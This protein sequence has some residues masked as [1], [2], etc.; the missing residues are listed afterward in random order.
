VVDG[1]FAARLDLRLP[2]SLRERL[3]AA[4]R[5]DRRPVTALARLLLEEALDA[6]EQPAPPVGTRT[7]QLIDAG[8]A[9]MP[10]R[11]RA[12]YEA[13]PPADGRHPFAPGGANGKCAECGQRKMTAVHGG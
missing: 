7:R 11:A 8:P 1:E 6:R 13:R 3:V 12:V 10:V 2:A 5:A 4:A 9:G